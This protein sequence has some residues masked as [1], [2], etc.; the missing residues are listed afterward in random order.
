MK[1]MEIE[2]KWD[3]N[4]PRAFYRATRALQTLCGT[5][6][7]QILPIQDIY[8]DDTQ[9]SLS[10]QL[11]ALRV[12]NTGGKWE[13]TLKTRTKIK[14]G[15]ATRREETLPLPHIQTQTQALH[16]LAKRKTWQGIS[17]R[18]LVPQFT[19]TNKRTIYVFTYQGSTLEMAL[20]RVRIYVAGRRVY[21]QE[22]EL[23]LKR[24]KTEN[25]EKFATVFSHQTKL[26]KAKISKVKTAE[27]L[28]KLWK[29]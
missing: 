21:M 28:R 18:D 29:N 19:L 7:A 3:A 15:K 24:G 11:I 23:E 10:K 4:S 27:M 16:A 13:A 1:H 12:R 8:L 6:T 17:T 2:Y 26:Q 5:L 25:L 20:D 14:N 22:I 9:H